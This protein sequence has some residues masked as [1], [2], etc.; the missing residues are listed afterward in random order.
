M[1][2][3]VRKMNFSFFPITPDFGLSDLWNHYIPLKYLFFQNLKNG[4]FLLWTDQL[5]NGFPIFAQG[6]VGALNL[7]NL[8]IFA[9]FPFSISLILF[10]FANIFV[11]I[12]GMYLLARFLKFSRIISLFV[13]LTFCFSGFFIGHHTHWDIFQAG[14][15]FPWV[16]FFYLKGISKNNLRNWLIFSF[17]IAQQIFSGNLQI[18]FITLI[19]L[20]IHTVWSVVTRTIP[21]LALLY[22]IFF[23]VFSL[24]LSAIQI[25]PTWEFK[26]QSIRDKGLSYEEATFFPYNFSDLKNFIYPFSNG[27]PA[28]GTYHQLNPN[29]GIFWENSGFI[30]LLAFFLAFLAFVN[31]KRR[32]EN[33]FFYILLFISLLFVL[34]K[35]SPLYFIYAFFPFNQFRIP[36]RFLLLSVVSLSF[37]S[38][39]F[40]EKL[41]KGKFK[42]FRFL[43]FL[44]IITNFFSQILFIKNY[45]P[46]VSL[47]RALNK[48][49]ITNLLELKETDKVYTL[50]SPEI[51]NKTFYEGWQNP[52]KFIDLQNFL[53]ANINLL[54]NINSGQIHNSFSLKRHQLTHKIIS[55]GLEIKESN[56]SNTKTISINLQAVNFLK[57]LGIN[58]LLSS[59]EIDN[60][61]VTTMQKLDKNL[62]KIYVYK[63]DEILPKFYFS[64]VLT[65]AQTVS[66]FVKKLQD[67]IFTKQKTVILN[68]EDFDLLNKKITGQEAEASIKEN[69]CNSQNFSVQFFQTCYQIKTKN[70]NDALLVFNNLYYP[71]WLAF[72]DGQKTEIF[73]ANLNQQAI[74]VPQGNHLVKFIYKPKNFFLGAKI[75]LISLLI[76]FVLFLPPVG[77]NLQTLLPFAR[78]ENTQD[79]SSSKK[80]KQ[81]HRRG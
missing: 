24:S 38:A 71:G 49:D 2:N 44:I 69:K 1:V 64:Q 68:N 76:L 79:K 13:G 11:G 62:G 75:S 47:K 4:R 53:P 27:N 36:S 3:L 58:Y 40:L 73:A 63:I 66:D 20:L 52:E 60:L 29:Q 32:Q 23:T 14:L 72:I 48:P 26:K 74:V 78:L 80:P 16:W 6:Q 22:L 41:S 31:K 61:T 37:L 45:I 51:W 43:V 77:R 56:E 15:L 67:P 12:L 21:K 33:Y 8:I 46:F 19:G 55:S 65:S 70:K 50:F 54:W 25:L 18:V 39:I 9:L 17:L 35:N 81:K 59:Y 30:G 7:L 34:G 57:T 28:S 10:Y 5:S 42:S